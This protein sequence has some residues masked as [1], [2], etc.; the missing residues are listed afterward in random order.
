MIFL[1]HFL[2]NYLIFLCLVATLKWAEKLFIDFS[3]LTSHEIELFFLF[4]L[5]WDIIVSHKILVKNNF[6]LCQAW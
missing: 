5:A 3:Y 4:S 2:E 1:K 6:I